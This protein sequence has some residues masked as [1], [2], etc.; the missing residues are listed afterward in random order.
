MIDTASQTQELIS[1]MRQGWVSPQ[2]ALQGVGCMRLAAR[3][4]DIK[5]MGYHVVSRY[6]TE[7]GRGGKKIR[8]KEYRIK[9]EA[10]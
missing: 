4:S 8:F 7:T 5:R 10:A 1:L 9:E 3:V 2:M 6:V